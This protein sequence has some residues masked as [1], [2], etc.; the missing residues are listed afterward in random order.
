MIAYITLLLSQVIYREYYEPLQ[1]DQPKAKRNKLTRWFGPMKTWL[2]QQAS[3][4]GASI[5]RWKVTRQGRRRMLKVRAIAIRMQTKPTHRM[6]ALMAF[7]AVAMQ[8]SGSGGYDNMA[9]F[10]TDSAPIGVDNRCTGCISHKIED[11]EGPLTES[12]RSIKGFGGSK[13]ANV[14]I[15]TIVWKWQDDNGAVHKFIIPKSFYVK[16]G[17]VRLL[18]PQHW[19][20]TQ[21]DAK[22]KQGTGSETV[23]DRV[24]LFW[25]QRK[26]KLTIPLSRYNNVAT[27]NLAPG[28]TK[29]MG[30]CAE[31]EVDY[32][33]EQLDPIICYPA[34]TVSDDE[35]E[36]DDDD[37][38]EQPASADSGSAS[39]KQAHDEWA[40]P[41]NF[42]LDGKQ[43]ANAPIIIEDE[44]DRQPTN[45]AA[46]LL[47]YHHQFG[48][49]SFRVL[50]VMAKLGIIPKRL[51]KCATPTCSACLYAK[52]IKRAWRSRTTSNTDE[53]RKPKK[54][55]ECV[56]VD[57]LVSPTPGL[58][59][60]MSGFLTMKRYKYATVYVDQASRLS[61]VWLQQGATADETLEGK[62]AFEQYAKER[63]VKIQAYHADNGIFRAHKWVMACRAQGQSLSFA[64]V[65]AH[66]QNGIAERRIRTLQELARTMLIHANHRWPKAVTANLWPYALRMANDVLSETPNMKHPQ[67]LTPQ[68]VF[69]NTEV[70]P[71]PKHWKPFGCPTY[72][73]DPSLQSNTGI[74]HKWKQRSRVGIYIGRSPQHARSVALVL[75]R[76]TGLV[77]PQ[78]HIKFDP[79][80]QTVKGDEYDSLWQLKTGFVGLKKPPTKVPPTVEPSTA[81]HKVNWTNPSEGAPDP[82]RQRTEQQEQ[83]IDRGSTSE[84]NRQLQ[85]HEVNPNMDFTTGK[86]PEKPPESEQREPVLPARKRQPV[87][88]LIEAMTAEV[89]T[90][91]AKGIKGEIFCLEAMFFQSEQKTKTH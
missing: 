74:F 17:N 59:A 65:N 67:K 49:I 84:I 25:K 1:K 86:E 82:K 61:F 53:A 73:L 44:E 90:L 43:Q 33:A 39:S 47:R 57:Q 45:Q 40:T 32:A 83:E 34:Q 80:F 70:Q 24:T 29:F 4:A 31:A 3:K 69:S 10:D 58:I 91:T 87:E 8:A 38:Y 28:Y 30:F 68:Q 52:A 72:V 23:G 79:S 55:G 89:N 81:R 42:D 7:T 51:S 2:I 16:E 19:A 54:P 41:T 18:S 21:K 78:F 9:M 27:F 76:R 35:A 56:S 6:I 14:M 46:E 11:F 50:V 26:H 60:Q 22:P 64:G 71:N 62:E 20:Q 13:T 88:R 48:H 12:N 85:R 75:D 37:V 36:P 66:H 5:D 63:G 77:S 15:G